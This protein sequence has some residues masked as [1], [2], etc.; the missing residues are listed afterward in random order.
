L[1]KSSLQNPKGDQKSSFIYVFY[2]YSFK[3]CIVISSESKTH[4]GLQVAHFLTSL[5]QHLGIYEQYLFLCSF[6]FSK[7]FFSQSFK[8]L[9]SKLL[10]IF[11]RCLSYSFKQ[12]FSQSFIFKSIWKGIMPFDLNTFKIDWK[13]L[14]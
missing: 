10:N 12:L 4:S 1:T 14:A 2:S 6:K 3:S 11:R 13:Y 7:N 9:V 8:S 5:S